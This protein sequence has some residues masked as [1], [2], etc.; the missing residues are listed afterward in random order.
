MAVDSL[1]LDLWRLDLLGG[2]R[3]SGRLDLQAEL[4]ARH[5][6]SLALRLAL[7]P[8]GGEGALSTLDWADGRPAR[9]LL[10]PPAG[11][12]WL[13]VGLEVEGDAVSA[14]AGRL[15]LSLIHI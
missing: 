8:E 9:L 13:E 3:L 7:R 6:P 1:R 11:D 2:R 15:E 4:R 5:A 14:R 12:P 10:S